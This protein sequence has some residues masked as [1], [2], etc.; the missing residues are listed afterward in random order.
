VKLAH[1]AD[2][3]LGFRQ[4]ARQTAQGINQ[5]EADVAGAFRRALD[6]V[7]AQRPDLIVIAGDLFHSVRPTNTA[8]LDAFRRFQDLRARLP[9][10]PVVLVSGNHDTPRSVETG[11]ILRLFEAIPGIQVVTHEPRRLVF[12]RLGVAV[13][14]VPNAAWGMPERPSVAPDPTAARN[15]LVT[16]REVEGVLP[17]EAAAALGYG[18][19][20]IRRSELR[21]EAFDYVALGHYHV[22]TRV[23][24][25]VWYA[26]ALEYVTTNP[27]G[28]SREGGAADVAGA[29]GW[30]LA[31]LG[32]RLTVRFRPVARARRVLDL[33]PI[34]GTALEAAELDRAIAERAAAVPEG[35]DGQIVR[36]VVHNVARVTARDL[37]HAA[38]RALKS[39]ALHYRLDLRRPL[40]PRPRGVSERGGR[41]PLPVLVEEYLRGREL[42]PGVPRERFVG[43]G[44]E[45]V[46]H[47]ER[48]EV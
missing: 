16:H 8:I 1:L 41:Q 44:S 40:A 38:I 17:Y 23:D 15:I 14:C 31:T 10:A 11:S 48:E 2:L 34:E 33:D 22:P 9:E 27:W 39:R 29:K 32:D 13:L 12:E 42:P 19:P 5:R 36:Q 45:Y 35:L 24:R 3:H 18:G 20:P 26:G 46:A 30:L 4:Y 47:A 43:L 37:D 21:A 28:E 25:N 7:V 6:D